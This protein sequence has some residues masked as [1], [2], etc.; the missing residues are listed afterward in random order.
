MAI[1]V[2]SGTRFLFPEFSGVIAKAERFVCSAP[3]LSAIALS[4]DSIVVDACE[5]FVR[6]ASRVRSGGGG[7]EDTSSTSGEKKH[8][9]AL[10]SHLTFRSRHLS[11]STSWEKRHPGEVPSHLTFLFP[12]LRHAVPESAFGSGGGE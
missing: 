11:H 4:L 8:S 5:R 7:S 6:S 1:A 12:Y 2:S 3:V 10:P 9:G